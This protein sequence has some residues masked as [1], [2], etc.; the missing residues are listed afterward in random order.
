MNIIVYNC[1]I[2]KAIRDSRGG[3]IQPGIEYCAGWHDFE[4]MGISC[5]CAYETAQHRYRVFCDDNMRDFQ[6]LI[7]RADTLIGFNNIAFDNRMLR[8][9]GIEIKD[10]KCYDILA[11]IWEAAGLTRYFQ[12]PS[13]IGYG[14]DEMIRVNFEGNG[15]SSCIWI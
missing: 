8:A 7:D 3:Y 14:L 4:N 11:E 5:T 15:N 12:Y 6:S 1:E 2:K 13:H 10:Q 9:N